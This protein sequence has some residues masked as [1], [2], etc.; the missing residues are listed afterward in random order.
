MWV[1]TAGKN[2]P[3]DPEELEFLDGLA[4]AE[5]ARLNEA[6]QAERQELEEFRMVR[7]RRSW[8]AI[9]GALDMDGTKIM[10]AEQAARRAAAEA[11]GSAGELPQRP[12]PK[13]SSI[14]PK[15]RASVFVLS[16]NRLWATPAHALVCFTNS[17]LLAFA[18][19]AHVPFLHLLNAQAEPKRP[20]TH[21]PRPNLKPIVRPKAQAPK[22]AGQG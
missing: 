13:P 8:A 5:A 4:Q 21:Y 22:T 7:T 18:A 17:L 20:V 1:V 6:S 16:S 14:G 9:A 11:E 12:A 10:L 15:V 3:L 2:A 19:L